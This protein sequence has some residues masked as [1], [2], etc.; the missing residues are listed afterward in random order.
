[1]KGTLAHLGEHTTEDREVRGSSPRSPIFNF[2]F[3]SYHYMKFFY[4]NVKVFKQ[5]HNF[6]CILTMIKKIGFS[7]FFLE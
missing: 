4:Y 2:V 3:L 7:F 1:M 5:N 6:Q